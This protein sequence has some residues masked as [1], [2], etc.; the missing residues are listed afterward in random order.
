MRIPKI[1]VSVALVLILASL[2]YGQG[3]ATG[4]L[5]VAVKAPQGQPVANATV[6]A[7]DQ[8][9]GIERPASGNGQGEYSISGLPPASYTVTVS[10]AGFTKATASDVGITVGGSVALP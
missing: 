6:I 2:V 1:V 9:K 5:H 8:A 4:D 10:A 7:R 3:V